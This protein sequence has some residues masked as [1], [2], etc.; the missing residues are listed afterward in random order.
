MFWARHDRSPATAFPRR[1][2]DVHAVR[3]LVQPQWKL[4]SGQVT[5]AVDHANCAGF[6]RRNILGMMST[7]SPADSHSRE[8]AC[9]RRAA[10]INDA[11]TTG[12][13]NAA[14]RCCVPALF[15]GGRPRPGGGRAR[16]Q[17]MD[18]GPWPD[19]RGTRKLTALEESGTRVESET[20]LRSRGFERNFLQE[21]LD[22]ILGLPL[23]GRGNS[24]RYGGL[25]T[26]A[27][28]PRSEVDAVYDRT[29]ST[30]H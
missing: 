24:C 8:T 6:L 16:A 1:P 9:T 21:G 28:L 26:S 3:V 14:D 11:S 18:E 5:W 12:F 30:T 10:H 2:R 20:K 4:T 25:E 27:L 17:D 22:T 23:L 7:R 19:F 15:A 29:R 13:G